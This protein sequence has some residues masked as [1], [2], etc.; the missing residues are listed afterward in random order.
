MFERYWCRNLQDTS[1]VSKLVDTIM[2]KYV[3]IYWIVNNAGLFD[4]KISYMSIRQ[5]LILFLTL[6]L[7]PYFFDSEF[8]AGTPC[9]R[10]IGRGGI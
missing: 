10:S 4:D 1:N 6:I 9:I 8:R 5:I 7:K 3:Y 2:F